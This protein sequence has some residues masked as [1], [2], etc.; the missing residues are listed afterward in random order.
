MGFTRSGSRGG[1]QGNLLMTSNR[2]LHNRP[3]RVSLWHHSLVWNESWAS[4]LSTAQQALQ[5]RTR[6]HAMT[7][8]LSLPQSEAKTWQRWVTIPRAP[9]QWGGGTMADWA[10]IIWWKL[11]SARNHSITGIQTIQKDVWSRR[12]EKSLASAHSTWEWVFP[13][14]KPMLLLNLSQINTFDNINTQ[15]HTEQRL[16]INLKGHTAKTN[17]TKTQK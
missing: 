10:Q 4:Q 8:E 11:V 6:T 15:F 16:F 2:A 12:K 3:A 1:C 5:L 9:A 14:I 13:L 17:A 7:G